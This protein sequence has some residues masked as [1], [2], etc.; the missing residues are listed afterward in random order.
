M[1]PLS[2]V[3][4]VIRVTPLQK[5]GRN[6]G[7]N[8]MLLKGLWTGAEGPARITGSAVPK[9]AADTDWISSSALAEKCPENMLC[10]RPR[11]PAPQ[12]QEMVNLFP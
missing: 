10:A 1:A 3:T 5:H 11:T 9:Q 7:C 12:D 4:P 6:A 2:I 8:A